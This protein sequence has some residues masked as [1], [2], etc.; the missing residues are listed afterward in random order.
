MYKRDIIT[1][2]DTGKE[3]AEWGEEKR[4]SSLA[5]KKC[6]R[7]CAEQNEFQEMCKRQWNHLIFANGQS[8][9]LRFLPCNLELR[10]VSLYCQK[11]NH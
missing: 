2:D 9:F 8:L 11:L 6:A 1:R 7:M 10:F 5:A 4:K 3:G